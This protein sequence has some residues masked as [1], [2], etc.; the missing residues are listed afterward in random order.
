MEWYAII[1]EEVHVNED[2]VVDGK[3]ENSYSGYSK[4]QLNVL[5]NFDNLRSYH[6]DQKCRLLLRKG[7]YPC[8]YMPSWN[9]FEE[10]A[11]L[12][13]GQRKQGNIV[14]EAKLC[15]RCKKCFWKISKTYFDFKTQILCLQHMLRGGG[16][17]EA[18]VKH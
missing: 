13:K 16:N 17:E 14:A 12:P 11:L 3:C 6:S 15:P 8:Q 5:N 18:F 9:K 10:T 4:R 2:N 1:A 7:I